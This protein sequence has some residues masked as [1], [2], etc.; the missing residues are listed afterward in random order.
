LE[1]LGPVADEAVAVVAVTVLLSVLAHGVS[2]A[3]LAARYGR[4]AAAAGPEAGGP[5]D[6]IELRPGSA[7]RR[8]AG[9]RV[10]DTTPAGHG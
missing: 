7:A 4:A 2:A 6:V 1:G 5:V 9:R 3:P 10:D 8:R